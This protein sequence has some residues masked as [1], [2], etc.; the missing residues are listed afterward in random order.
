M[1]SSSERGSRCGFGGPG[2]PLK[3]SMK[4]SQKPTTNARHGSTSSALTTQTGGS[5]ATLSLTYSFAPNWSTVTTA[6]IT[7]SAA[8]VTSASSANS[9]KSQRPTF[10]ITITPSRVDH[11]TQITDHGSQIAGC[12]KV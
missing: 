1:R 9:R 11:E 3:L 10:A 5:P 12:T 2:G 4:S 7:A 8:N 6:K